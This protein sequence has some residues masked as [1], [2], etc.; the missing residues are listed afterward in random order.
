MFVALAVIVVSNGNLVFGIL[1]IC[2]TLL[3]IGLQPYQ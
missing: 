2:R 3:I 1:E